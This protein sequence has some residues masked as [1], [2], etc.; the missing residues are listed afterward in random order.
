ME[1]EEEEGE[2]SGKPG[3][4]LHSTVGELPISGCFP[5]PYF[6][7]CSN[8]RFTLVSDVFALLF[9]FLHCFFCPFAPRHPFAI[10]FLALGAFSGY[11]VPTEDGKVPLGQ[12]DEI[13]FS[14]EPNSPEFA[15]PGI[16]FRGH[17]ERLRS[18]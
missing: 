3:C 10:V 6:Y 4:W 1:Q 2:R 18:W 17:C 12:R 14:L 9:I 11:W 13:C 5:V 8:V 16:T 15:P 7:L